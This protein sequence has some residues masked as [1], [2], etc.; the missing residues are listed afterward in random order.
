M[1]TRGSMPSPITTRELTLT[2]IPSSLYTSSILTG[3]DAEMY[4]ETRIQQG[5]RAEKALLELFPN[6]FPDIEYIQRTLNNYGNYPI[7]YSNYEFKSENA[8]SNL[9][10]E[11]VHKWFTY[12]SER[13]HSRFMSSLNLTPI[14]LTNSSVLLTNPKI[15]TLSYDIKTIDGIIPE[16]CIL[17]T[18]GEL[19][20]PVLRYQRG[21]EG[22]LY[23]EG[24]YDSSKHCGTY[25]FLDAG[26]KVYLKSNKTLIV[27]NP[28]I[29]YFIL[30]GA[31]DKALDKVVA[32]TLHV[33]SD[34]YGK[35]KAYRKWILD[36]YNSCF[37]NLTKLSDFDYNGE[38][39]DI[40]IIEETITEQQVCFL[41][42]SQ[43]IEVIIYSYYFYSFNANSRRNESE[44][45]DVRI[46]DKNSPSKLFRAI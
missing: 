29:A 16:P 22:S 35:E 17:L 38:V 34:R 44:I 18:D 12:P 46:R 37:K 6:T 26:P 19:Y 13:T 1:S 42:R 10:P 9:S 23:Y 4:I 24:E 27:P 28:E 2:P 41:A 39:H 21:E 33:S 14:D 8:N 43:G 32:D 20:I 31:D 40:K 45:V 15:P 36:M 25:Y 11:F 7:D 3:K 5:A 30:L